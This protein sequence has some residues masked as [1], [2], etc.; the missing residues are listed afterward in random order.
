MRNT[1]HRIDLA[2]VP[3]RWGEPRRSGRCKSVMTYR[4]RVLGESD[5]PLYD[6]ARRLL[7][8]GL[9]APEDVIETFRGGWPHMRATVGRACELIV[10]E[11]PPGSP[12]K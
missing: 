1:I 2:P 5:A 8:L 10:A 3:H 6:G 9:A 4:G 12:L 7:Y 11:T